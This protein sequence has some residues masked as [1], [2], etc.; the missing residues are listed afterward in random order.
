VQA[1]SNN[2][3]DELVS[4]VIKQQGL[5]FSSHTE[6]QQYLK[7][8]KQE[9]LV[10]GQQCIDQLIAG[11]QYLKEN[12]RGYVGGYV[13]TVSS[14]LLQVLESPERF[15]ATI[16]EL[17]DDEQSLLYFTETVKEFFDCQDEHRAIC[18]T[19]VLLTIFP[20]N[21]QPYI[22]LGTLIWRKY[23]LAAAADY[24]SKMIEFRPEPV[25]LYFAAD[26]FKK[27]GNANDAKRVIHRALFKADQE[28]DSDARHHLL[29]FLEQL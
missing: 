8:T 5:H 1:I 7:K 15:A 26:C 4:S 25:F 21:P 6:A 17:V 14:K 24:Y 16:K 11:L 12:N 2:Q 10:C 29:E 28:N 23:G 27:N 3:I 19:T 18:G 9:F 22:L 13:S 20:L